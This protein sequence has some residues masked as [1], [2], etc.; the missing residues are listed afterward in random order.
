MR[1]A[2]E[3]AA[4]LVEQSRRVES[5]TKVKQISEPSSYLLPAP[6]RIPPGR[7]K[8][9]V[10]LIFVIFIS[11]GTRRAKC[12]ITVNAGSWFDYEICKIVLPAWAGSAFSIFNVCSKKKKL[13]KTQL[14]HGTFKKV[15][16]AA[17]RSLFSL[18][19]NFQ[20]IAISIHIVFAI[21]KS[22]L[23]AWAGCTIP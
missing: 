19:T 11:L 23:P 6:L 15:F 10:E 20:N 7:A 1:G 21:F 13:L 18:F 8:T 5:R 2:I 3:S 12:K 16:P 4:C 17:A 14:E 22:V 9:T